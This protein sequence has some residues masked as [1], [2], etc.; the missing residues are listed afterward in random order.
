MFVPQRSVRLYYEI[1]SWQ[2][3]LTV[4]HVFDNYDKTADCAKR[5]SFNNIPHS[6]FVALQVTKHTEKC[7]YRKRLR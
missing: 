5:I 6:Y 4:P 2:A 3:E 1:M 7:Q